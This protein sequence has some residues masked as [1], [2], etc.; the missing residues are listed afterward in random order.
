VGTSKELPKCVTTC[1]EKAIEVKEVQ[2]DMEKDIYLVGDS[3]AVHS[4]K[5]SREDI[6]PPKKK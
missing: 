3:L 2:E 1:P 4:R 6:Q 5:W